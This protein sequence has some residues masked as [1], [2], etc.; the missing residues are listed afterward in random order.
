MGPDGQCP[1]RLR[2]GPFM[3]SAQCPTCCRKQTPTGHPRRSQKCHERTFRVCHFAHLKRDRCAAMTPGP[4][5]QA[6]RDNP[7]DRHGQDQAGDHNSRHQGVCVSRQRRNRQHDN[8]SD[9]EQSGVHHRVDERSDGD[10]RIELKGFVTRVN[11][12]VAWNCGHNDGVI[13]LVGL[14]INRNLAFF[15]LDAEELTTVLMNFRANLLALL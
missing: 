3:T 2:L 11:Q 8:Q 13:A 1:D 6:R 10:S 15:V 4:G 7:G 12:V 5:T 9:A 14:P